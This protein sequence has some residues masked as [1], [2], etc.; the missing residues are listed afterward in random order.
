MHDRMI[1]SSAAQPSSSSEASCSRRRDGVGVRPSSAVSFGRELWADFLLRCCAAFN[2]IERRCVQLSFVSSYHRH[3]R[4][5]DDSENWIGKFWW[6]LAGGNTFCCKYR[7]VL[8]FLIV[9]DSLPRPYSEAARVSHGLCTGRDV[10]EVR[11]VCGPFWL[12]AVGSFPLRCCAA[13][14]LITYRYAQSNLIR[15]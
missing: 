2:P 14:D 1:L 4:A 3:S 13:F 11:L 5:H 12:G 10:A 6:E 9:R 8:S 7:R 15:S